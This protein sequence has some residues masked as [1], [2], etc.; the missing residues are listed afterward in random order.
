[1]SNV[2]GDAHA[3]LAALKKAVGCGGVVNEDNNTVEIQGEKVD[4]VGTWLTK[5]GCL[6]GVS[7]Q[8]A[9]GYIFVLVVS[10]SIL[11]VLEDAAPKPKS[12]AKKNNSADGGVIS[13]PAPIPELPANPQSATIAIKKMKP[14]CCCFSC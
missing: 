2:S 9:L 13:K 5:S 3:L 1:M 8:V 7:K 6:K 14:V 11:Q 4:R 12:G 10:F